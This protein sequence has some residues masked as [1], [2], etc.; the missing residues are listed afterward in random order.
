MMYDSDRSYD[1]TSLIT[2]MESLLEPEPENENRWFKYL[3]F[4]RKSVY[5]ICF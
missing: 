4:W 2:I 5:D 1:A 3:C